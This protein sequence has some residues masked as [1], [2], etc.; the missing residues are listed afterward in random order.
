MEAAYPNEVI[1]ISVYQEDSKAKIEVCNKRLIPQDNI[2]RIFH[3]SFST[4]GEN[5]GLG[6]YS[7]KLLA[8][9]YLKGK[10]SVVSTEET[11]TIFTLEL[12]IAK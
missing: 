1:K 11:G 4:K 9:K 7:V 12:P 2:R 5:R 6:T 3:R 10:V 8:E